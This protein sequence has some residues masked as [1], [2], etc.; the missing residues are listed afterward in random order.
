MYELLIWL[1]NSKKLFF[2]YTAVDG[3][4]TRLDD[5]M[6]RDDDGIDIEKLILK[7]EQD[8]VRAGDL[9]KKLN[10]FESVLLSLEAKGFKQVSCLQKANRNL[11]T[12]VFDFRTE[13]FI[14]TKRIKAS[15][16]YPVPDCQQTLD[17]DST[18]GL[19]S[20][21]KVDKSC[22]LNKPSLVYLLNRRFL[23]TRLKT[24]VIRMAFLLAKIVLTL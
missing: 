2:F 17:S 1:G 3:M 19:L 9:Y 7:S 22:F 8:C 4:R 11:L 12:H 16:S 14:N 15:S 6:N 21:I 13:E 20:H 24:S 5:L 18:T 23:S 10:L